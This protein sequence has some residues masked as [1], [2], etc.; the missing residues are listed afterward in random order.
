MVGLAGSIHHGDPQRGGDLFRVDPLSD[1]RWGALLSR[2]PSASVFHSPEWLRALQRTY[3]YEP[4]VFT[5]S[6][7]GQSLDDGIIFC[8]VKSLLTGARLVSLPFSDHCQLL[9]QDEQQLGSF[10]PRLK[11]ELERERCR[12]AEIR[13]IVSAADHSATR[14]GFAPTASFYYHALDLRPELNTLY[15]N[16]HKDCTQ[17]KIQRA[18]REHLSYEAGR[19]ELILQK[20]YRLQMLTRRRHRLPPQPREW[21][22]NLVDCL[23]DRLLIRV[24]SKDGRPIAAIVTLSFKKTLVYKYGCSDARFHNLGGMP[25]LFWK[26]IEEGKQQ[27]AE[28]LDL[29]RSDTDNPG[30]VAFKEHLGATRSELTYL[31]L[32]SRKRDTT[33]STRQLQLVRHAIALMPSSVAQ[34]MGSALYRH[35]G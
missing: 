1:P 31:R 25:L 26:A 10:F 18:S 12:Y 13:P 16:L 6:P 4:V 2:H 15:R 20:F 32:G 19:S 5:T 34:M 11:R 30:L 9:V 8:R 24:L 3:D 22:R 17:R 14:E 7:P 21:F 27:G 28:E 23:G 29:G 35:M 33:S